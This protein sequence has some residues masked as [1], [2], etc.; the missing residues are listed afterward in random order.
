VLGLDYP[1]GGG[2]PSAIEGGL[3]ERWSD[4]P[5]AG[6]D[7]HDIHAIVDEARR[8]AIPGLPPRNSGTSDARGIKMIDALGS[9]F[10]C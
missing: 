9:M 6:I 4:R 7:G 1:A 2:E 5:I 3:A 10:K 8:T